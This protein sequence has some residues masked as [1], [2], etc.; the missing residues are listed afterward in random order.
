MCDSVHPHEDSE[1][2]LFFDQSK[3]DICMKCKQ[4]HIIVKHNQGLFCKNCFQVYIIHKFRAAIGRTK[5]IKNGEEVLIA[6]SGG[7]N[8]AALLHLIHHG[9]SEKAHRKLR[10]IPSVLFV[11]EF[12]A[13]DLSTEERMIKRSEILELLSDAG[14]PVYVSCLEQALILNRKEK[15]DDSFFSQVT[16]STMPLP[17]KTYSEELKVIINELSS[18]T[19]IEDFLRRLR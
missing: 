6:F 11:D 3:S 14:F 16:S 17:L 1:E 15:I 8:S 19:S 4:P 18:L 9:K 2:N 5:L 7:S 13:L 10:F 12:A